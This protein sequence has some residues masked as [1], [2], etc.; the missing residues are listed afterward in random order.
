MKSIC[1]LLLCTCVI[2]LHSDSSRADCAYDHLE[3]GCNE[4]GEP[5]T[6]D[7]NS[8]FLDVHHLYRRTDPNHRDDYT[9]L[10]WYYTLYPVGGDPDASTFVISEPGFDLIHADEDPNRCLTGT[11]N[12][13][14]R[15]VIQCLD[16]SPGF[17]AASLFEEI[18]LDEAGD[19]FAHSDLSD[20]HVHLY[21]TAPAPGDSLHWIR[22]RAVDAFY[23]PAD[24]NS[25]YQPSRPVT[26]VFGRKPLD[27]DIHVDGH[28]N[29][30]DL[31][32]LTAAWLMENDCPVWNPNKQAA[33]DLFDRADINRDYR[34]DLLDFNDLTRHWKQ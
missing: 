6:P 14:Y 17:Q 25:G 30:L 8:L 27:G 3:I 31:E 16:L 7:D 1:T 19:A 28:V 2:L 26:V 21:Y 20:P 18:L 5:N 33:F 32:K 15:I 4:D 23:D 24:P 10:N 34:V 22:Y 13:D 29:L 12:S 9:W 11:P